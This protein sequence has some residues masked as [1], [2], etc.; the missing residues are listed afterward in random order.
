MKRF[1]L[2]CLLGSAM[3]S[4]NAALK[5]GDTAPDFTA[6]ASQAGK[7]SSYSLKE[8]LKKGPVVVYFYPSAFTKGCN[9]QAHSFAVNFDKFAAAGAGIVGVSLDN[10]ARL[11]EFSADPEFCAGKFP[12]ASDEDGKISKSFELDVREAAPGKKDTR[13]NDITHGFAERTTFIVTPDGKIA[14]SIG[15]LKAKENVDKALE[16]VQHLTVKH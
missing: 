5:E 9:L 10:I 6:Q 15:G 1:L 13:G 4:A 7:A 2:A 16:V 12:V 3:L 14:A 8:A 11:N